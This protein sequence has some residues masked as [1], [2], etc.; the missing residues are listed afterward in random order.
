MTLT[1]FDGIT[2]LNWGRRQDPHL[3]I[4]DF[5]DRYGINYC[6]EGRVRISVDRQAPVWH[7]GPVA[8]ISRPGHFEYGTPDRTPWSNRFLNFTGP[9]ALTFIENGLLD[10]ARPVLPVAQGARFCS[11]MDELLDLVDSG[12]FHHPRAVHLLEGLLLILAEQRTLTDQPSP[13]LKAILGWCERIRAN[14]EKPWD[15]DDMAA[16]LRLSVSG[17]RKTFHAV[18]GM[19][20]H[21][22]IL[23]TRMEVS[24]RLLARHPNLQIQKIAE[25]VGF[26]DIYAFSRQFKNH[27]KQS[28]K[29]WR[30]EIKPTGKID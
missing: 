15:S 17:F 3:V 2:W 28:P 18:T 8:W 9:R 24:A 25:R 1:H 19:P 30:A 13:R 7:D 27:F 11:A 14:P 16:S 10:V 6:H 23:R 4:R 26:P 12:R 5:K 21:Q 22:Y 20:P 29:S